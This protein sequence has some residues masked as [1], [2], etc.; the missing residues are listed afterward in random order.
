MD[1]QSCIVSYS[2]SVSFREDEEERDN[3][4]ILIRTIFEIYLKIYIFVEVSSILCLYL[5][6]HKPCHSDVLISYNSNIG[7]SPRLQKFKI[8]RKQNIY[9]FF[10]SWFLLITSNSVVYFLSLRLDQQCLLSSQSTLFFSCYVFFFFDLIY[11]CVLL[12]IQEV[13]RFCLLNS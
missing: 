1:P 7:S 10:V 2:S 8:L 13:F 6:P 9:P 5:R 12:Y 4:P 11:I 3:A